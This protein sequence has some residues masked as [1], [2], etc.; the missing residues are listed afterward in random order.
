MAPLSGIA[1][2]TSIQFGLNE[3]FKRIFAGSKHELCGAMAGIG[4]SL[5]STPVEHI[6]IRMQ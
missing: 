3:F 1:L 5:V 2:C 4:T 6:R